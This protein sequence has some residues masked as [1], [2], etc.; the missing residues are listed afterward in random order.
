[1]VCGFS[2]LKR[3]EGLRKELWSLKLC[4]E[5]VFRLIVKHN[6]LAL[7]YCVGTRGD[8]EGSCVGPFLFETATF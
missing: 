3:L 8:E 6:T 7:R 2:K 1:M 5:V 4:F